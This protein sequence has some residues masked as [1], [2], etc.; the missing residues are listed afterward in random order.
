MGFKNNFDQDTSEGKFKKG[1]QY[2]ET[3]ETQ[4]KKIW[5]RLTKLRKLIALGYNNRIIMSIV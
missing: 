5:L 2:L 1:Y 4:R 3:C